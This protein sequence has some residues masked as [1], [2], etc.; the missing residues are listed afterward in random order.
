MINTVF[1]IVILLVLH[2]IIYLMSY[3]QVEISDYHSA[4]VNLVNSQTDYSYYYT[5]KSIDHF[6]HFSE[7]SSGNWFKEI[8]KKDDQLI[9]TDVYLPSLIIC[10][11]SHDG[12]SKSW[13]TLRDINDE[14]WRCR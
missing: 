2:L 12:K 6:G 5:P 9:L 13:E 3:P 10:S 11:N 8:T 4:N 7:A 1:K 14:Y